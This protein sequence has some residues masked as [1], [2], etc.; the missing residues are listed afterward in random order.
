LSVKKFRTRCDLHDLDLLVRTLL[1]Q[2]AHLPLQPLDLVL[3]GRRNE[4]KEKPWGRISFSGI[5]PKKF[6][7]WHYFQEMQ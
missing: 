7:V 3:E 1:L 6:G 4:A 5:V 2:L